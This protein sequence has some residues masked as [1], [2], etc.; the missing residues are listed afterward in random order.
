MQGHDSIGS[1][2]GKWQTSEKA[3]QLL[4]LGRV[5]RFASGRQFESVK[6]S[7]ATSTFLLP[8]AIFVGFG[9]PSL[10]PFACLSSSPPLPPLLS[11]LDRSN[12]LEARTLWRRRSARLRSSSIY[13][14]SWD[15]SSIGRHQRK[16]D[17]GKIIDQ[18]PSR[19]S[20]IEVYFLYSFH[21]LSII[22]IICSF[23]DN[24]HSGNLRLC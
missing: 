2:V 7:D 8:F 19:E 5:D 13:F 11:V 20:G 12:K 9:F 1:K 16:Q 18:P 10:L 6:S 23:V 21:Y 15:L 3:A 22:I 4:R 24:E 17:R 14:A